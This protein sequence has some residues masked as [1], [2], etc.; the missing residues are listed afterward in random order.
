MNKQSQEIPFF[1]FTLAPEELK[2]KWTNAMQGVMIKGHFILGDEVRKFEKA[3]AQGN[4][5]QY[6]VGVSN[7][8]D[9]LILA[10][11]ALGVG[12]GDVVVVPAHSFIATHNAVISLGATPYSVDVDN[13]GLLTSLTLEN[14]GFIPKAVI[15]VHM[16]GQMCEMKEIVSWAKTKNVYLIEDC[17]QAHF[18]KSN[19]KNSGTLG[20]IGVFSLYPTKNLGALGDAG[21]VVTNHVHLHDKLRSLTNYGSTPGNK[22]EHKSFGLNNRLDE[23]QAAIL[24]VNLQFLEQWNQRRREIANLYF[25]GLCES[26]IRFLQ[27]NLK[28]NVWHHF[29]ILHPQRDTLKSRL[30]EMGIQTEIHYPNVASIEC[31]KYSNL[32]E[33]EYPEATCISMQTL[34]LPISQWHSDS[35]I[36]TVIR[37]VRKVLSEI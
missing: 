22:Y 3:W 2:Q 13:Q 28:E 6:A 8:Q 35:D 19:G 32:E 29:C 21:V 23:I 30:L 26:K 9:G 25:D 17:S 5:N 37:S 31:E 18:A 15:V 33:G 1:S 11:R 7:G 27:K 34:S 16:H 10:L 24:N 20:D 14:L 36:E 4:G 12:T